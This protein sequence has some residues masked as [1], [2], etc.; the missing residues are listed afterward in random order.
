MAKRD[1]V[2]RAMLCFA[3]GSAEPALKSYI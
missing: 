1:A 2:R 3:S